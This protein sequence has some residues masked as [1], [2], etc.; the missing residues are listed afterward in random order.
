MNDEVA[1]IIS[2]IDRVRPFLIDDGGD[3]EF[4]KYEDDIVYV[5]LI[6]AC[7]NCSLIDNTLKQGIEQFIINEIP[8]V[9]EVINMP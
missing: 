3:I 8:T 1:K 4:I 5:R 7:A 6:G 9:K 2:V